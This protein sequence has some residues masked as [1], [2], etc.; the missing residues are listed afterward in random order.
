LDFFATTITTVTDR[1]SRMGDLSF[2]S[3]NFQFPSYSRRILG[4]A[5]K[6]QLMTINANSRR[7]RGDLRFFNCT[8]FGSDG[9]PLQYSG[10]N[11]E[12]RNNLWERNDWSGANT[13]MR[14][15]G[16]KATVESKTVNETFI[17]NTLKDN[18][19]SA[20]YRPWR[21]TNV[22]LNEMSGQCWGLIQN[23]GAAVQM[24]IGSQL[25]KSTLVNNWV[26]DS[27]KYGLRFD[28]PNNG[29]GWKKL[30]KDATVQSN[31]VWNTGVS[32]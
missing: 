7:G 32:W 5:K 24:M 25:A 11:V 13:D 29:V 20:G 21:E 12:V 17:R 18:G 23:D 10:G 8:W 3:L 30:G 6:P 16:G 2:E 28:C 26:H 15:S 1:W 31:V 22:Q 27:P 14:P 9:V 19:V 4:E